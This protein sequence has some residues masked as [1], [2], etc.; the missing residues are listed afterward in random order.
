VTHVRVGL[1]SYRST[2]WP[3]T[4]EALR[5]AAAGARELKEEAGASA[6]ALPSHGSPHARPHPHPQH[7]TPFPPRN[8]KYAAFYSKVYACLCIARLDLAGRS[9]YNIA[10]NV[11]HLGDSTHKQHGGG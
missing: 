1:R 9:L 8:P 11:H 5:P 4:R 10:S 2:H 6:P 3:F 7:P